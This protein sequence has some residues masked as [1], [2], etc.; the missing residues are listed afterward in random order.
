MADLHQDYRLSLF[1]HAP[2]SLAWGNSKSMKIALQAV[3]R[4]DALNLAFA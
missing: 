2:H 4:W 1:A 3:D